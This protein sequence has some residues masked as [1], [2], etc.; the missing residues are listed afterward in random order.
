MSSRLGIVF[1][2]I[3]SNTYEQM[4]QV[5]MLKV[6]LYVISKQRIIS[7]PNLSAVPVQIGLGLHLSPTS[8]NCWSGIHL[9]EGITLFSSPDRVDLV[10]D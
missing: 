9:P 4:Q 8:R 6:K 3:L 10:S 5:Q 1:E 7:S 2:S